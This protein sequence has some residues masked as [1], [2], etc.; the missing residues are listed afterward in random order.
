MLGAKWA[1]GSLDYHCDE[2]D[3]RIRVLAYA[4]VEELTGIYFV[5]ER[6][7]R[8]IWN[9]LPEVGPI[10]VWR[11]VLSRLQERYRNKKFVSIGIGEVLRSPAAARYEEGSR[12]AFLA[13]GLPACAERLALPEMFLTAVDPSA[14]TTLRDDAIWYVSDRAEKKPEGAWWDRVRGWSPYSGAVLSDADVRATRETIEEWIEKIDWTSGRALPTVPRSEIRAAADSSAGARRTGSDLARKRGVLFG[15]GHYAKT[16]ILPNVR[17][18][19]DV[20]KIHEVDPT[21]IPKDRS[22]VAWD[23]APMP[24]ESDDFDVFLIAGYHHTH[25]PLSVAALKCGAYAVAEKP[26]AVD[27]GQLMSLL[28]AMEGCRGGYFGCFHKRYSPLNDFAIEDLRQSPEEP[29]DYHCIVFEVPLPD[30]HWYHWPHSKSRLVSNGCHWIDH[31]LYLNG[32]KEV[33]SYEL[34]CSPSG[35]IQCSATLRNGA[36]FTMTLTDKGSERI[37][38]Q[39]YVELRSGQVTVKITNNSRYESENRTRVLRRIR[40]GKIRTYKL[41]YATIAERIARGE[42]GDSLQS[43]RVSTQLMLDLE[44]ALNQRIAKLRESV[45]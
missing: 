42:G 9:Y 26:L 19:I 37:G 7:P 15:Y 40:I 44:D 16:N 27:R 1:D 39:E 21:Q 34:G 12:V 18:R 31:F 8:L 23:T 4:N 14:C 3:Y 45:S 25:A 41:M 17:H 24:S 10:S 6:S 33:D 35:T 43:V 38:L 28:E 13:P 2:S 36:Y 5:R 20:E 32:Y 30:L 11:K 22:D 29:I